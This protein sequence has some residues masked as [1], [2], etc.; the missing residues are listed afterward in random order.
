ML[1][2]WVFCATG[3]AA[4]GGGASTTGGGGGWIS[5]GLPRTFTATTMPTIRSSGRTMNQS[6]Q[7]EPDEVDGGFQ[8]S[9][10]TCAGSVSSSPTCTTKSCSLPSWLK[11][12]LVFES[13]PGKVT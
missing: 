5:C 8:T 4:I 1:N 9:V 13:Q 10:T 7:S 2:I 11:W 3:G 6:H 12:T